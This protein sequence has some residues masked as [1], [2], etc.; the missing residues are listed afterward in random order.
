[1]TN[2]DS[3]STHIAGLTFDSQLKTLIDRGYPT[4]LGITPAELGRRLEPLREPVGT[5]DLPAP[6]LEAG[7]LPFVVV[8]SP[9]TVDAA[10]AISLTERNGKPGVEKLY[11]RR[12]EDF[13][14]LP[15][16]DIPQSFAYLLVDVD[17]GRDFI[18]V[19]PRDALARISENG[20]SP[21]T[22]HEGIACLTLYPEFLA[23][24]NCYS[25]AGSRYPGDKRVPAIWINKGGHPNLGW[26]W[27]GNPHTWLGT[28]HCSR[29]IGL[30]A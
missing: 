19:T 29:R 21:L 1:M 8:I 22:I 14:P 15:D 27:E 9:E 6:D 28:A 2:T 4:A 25:L 7:H 10:T 30:P 11:P 12:A 5:L 26:C 18:N 17:R 3:P 24:N 16:L 23:K 20:R 13:Q